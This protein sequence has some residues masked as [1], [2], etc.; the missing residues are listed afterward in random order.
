MNEK[1]M[2][3][4]VYPAVIILS[5]GTYAFSSSRGGSIPLSAFGAV[6]LG[7]VLIVLFEQL[8]PY[9]LKWRPRPEDIKDDLLYTAFIQIAFPRVLGFFIVLLLAN[10]IGADAPFA[11]IWPRE[12]PVAAQA[13]LLIISADFMRYWLHR[14]SHTAPLLWRLHAVHHSTDKL[15]WL[16][17]SR[18]HPSEKALQFMLD[19]LPF[20]LMG[21][22]P[23]VIGFW[24]VLYSVNGFFQHSN[25][26]LS[27]GP[28]SRIFSTAELHR[29]HHSQI[30]AESNS[31][32]ANVFILWD[33][34]FGTYY[35]PTGEVGTLGLLNP[36][37][38]M[39]IVQQMKAPFV[40]ELYRQNVSTQQQK[41]D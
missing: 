8:I 20:I 31:N 35:R 15:Y 19:S 36:D 17:T 21:V 13:L 39:G 25:I 3:S 38:P 30:P 26:R 10:Q 1:M 2:S 16:N 33:R 34:L 14:L 41:N 40:D 28:L 11:E 18:F 5:I 29:W 6:V 24:F 22:D 9:Q 12:W 32:Y 37:Y 7:A 27:F 23:H 4:L